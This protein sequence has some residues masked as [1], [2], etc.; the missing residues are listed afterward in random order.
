M[1]RIAPRLMRCLW[2]FMTR[3]MQFQ[4]DETETRSKPS[5]GSRSLL[6][7]AL[8]LFLGVAGD[9]LFS[10]PRRLSEVSQSSKEAPSAAFSRI[11][12]R[13]VVPSASPLRS[14]LLLA[15]VVSKEVTHRLV[16]PAIVEAD[17]G[18]TVKVLPPLAGRVVSLRVQLGERV[19]QGQELAV[20]DSG[21]LA[22]A[23]SDDQKGRTVL[24]LTKQ[25]LDRQLAL[26]KGGGAA[27]KDREQAQSDYAQAQF[28]FDRAETRLR[29]LGVSADQLEKTRLLSLKA[30]ITGSVTDLEVAAGDFLNDPTAT[31]M[32]IANLD[33]IWVTANVPEKDTAFVFAGQSV[34]VTFPAYPGETFSG[35]VL[36]VSDVLE[37]DTRRTKVRIAFDNPNK[38]FKPNMFANASFA[39]PA[40]SEIVVPTSALVM[41]NNSTSV[42]VEVAPWAFERRDVEI[43]HQDGEDAVIKSGINSGERVVVKGGVRL[44]D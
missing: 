12:N 9:R 20:I 4:Q 28:E 25:I 26:E 30:P 1:A 41:D 5:H 32:T 3:D 16:L 15:N 23:Y 27:I 10:P 37:P 38:N 17:P 31:I 44:N 42:F 40:V 18:R 19:A 43:R 2:S 39:A 22:Q 13:I 21:D 34:E 35:K 11:G 8:G 6:L 36:F 24:T 29:S 7:I 14:H 33:I